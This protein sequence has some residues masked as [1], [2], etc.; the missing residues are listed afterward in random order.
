ME[1]KLT[2]FAALLRNNGLLVSPPELADAV[3]AIAVIGYTDRRRFHDALSCTLA[4]SLQDSLTFERCFDLFFQFSSIDA[5]DSSKDSASAPPPAQS[6]QG[7][8]GSGGSSGSGS[9]NTNTPPSE[10]GIQLLSSDR[11]ELDI[12]MARAIEAA[13]LQDINVISQKGLYSHRILQAMGM[14]DF[15]REIQALGAI[16]SRESVLRINALRNARQS[17]RQ[18]IRETVERYYLLARQQNRDDII[19]DLDF[20]ALRDSRDVKRVVQRMAKRLVALHRRRQKLAARGMLDVKATLRHNIAYD[21]ILAEPRWKYI[22]KDK[23]RVMAI[24]DVSGS[25]SLH[26]RFL[27]M[28]LYSLQEVIPKLRAFAFSSSLSEVS[29]YFKQH[30]LDDAIDLVMARHGMGSTDY[31]RAL[32]DL[33]NLAC[34]EIDRRTTLIILGDAR[35]NNGEANA[36]LMHQFHDRAKQVIWLNPESRNRWGTGDSEMLRYLPACTSAW[37]CRNPG[38][39]ER[40]VDRLLKTA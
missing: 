16:N 38:E 37:S 11:S 27:L 6:G 23:P 3:H 31:G 29:D 22:R 1:R 30:T 9:D 20:S 26:A 10:L 15:E 12:S 36:N 5:E 33:N 17:L 8:M 21:G 4:K 19:R 28:F 7:N 39:L 35:N 25:V 40:I 2:E 18:Q 24:C 13:R 14:D 32:S 34:R